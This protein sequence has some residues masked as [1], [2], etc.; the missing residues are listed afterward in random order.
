MT[1]AS[2]QKLISSLSSSEKR[3]FK[4]QADFQ[5]GSKEYL[6]LFDLFCSNKTSNIEHLKE[7]FETAAKGE[8]ENTCNYLS[9]A[10][11][12]ALVSAKKENDVFLDLLQKIQQAKIL[13]ERSL[14]QEAF[15]LI[16][17]IHKAARHYHLI[18]IEYYCQR[19]ELNYHSENNFNKVSE[20]QLINQQM[21]G[22][23]TLKSFN[24]IHDHYSLYELLKFRL[25]HSGKIISE[26]EKKKLNDLMLSEIVLIAGKSKSFTSQKL[27]L[28]F[29]SFFFTDI[30]EYSSALESFFQLNDILEKNEL[31]F[32]NPPADYFS[33]LLGIIECLRIMNST[34]EIP[35][36]LDKLKT[37]D[38]HIYPEYFRY[39][40]KK[41]FVIQQM[42]TLLNAAAWEPALTF[43][44]GVSKDVFYSYNIVDEEK[45]SEL[46]FYSALVYF[47]NNNLKKAHLLIREIMTQF[48]LSRQ[49]VISRAIRLLNIIIYFEKGEI[50]HLEY[51]IRSYKRY[52]MQARM[53]K[54]E[55]LLL[56]ILSG[57]LGS[58]NR[59]LTI[60]APR[61]FPAAVKD[62][63]RDRY[64]YQLLKYFNFLD[65]IDTKLSKKNDVK[66]RKAAVKERPAK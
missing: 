19:Y 44:T 24:H 32:E 37:L 45:Q 65:W 52:F 21:S 35:F 3:Y 22:K 59:G 12:S 42:V 8:W 10:I 60:A 56:T 46:Y 31:L 4:L 48:K 17:T 38:Q 51:E 16:R 7:R 66:T 1:P 23:A 15:K 53:L 34:D 61:N 5:K 64:E 57:A 9:K 39:L 11:L 54:S 30:G 43:L 28:L 14:E 27:H 6:R 62:I 2:L 55:K 50:L 29:Q 20:E 58:K 13:K 33:A 25:T 63:D 41:S 26:S 49:L 18:W 36:Y 47:R 40:V